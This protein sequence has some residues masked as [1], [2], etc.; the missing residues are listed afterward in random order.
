M[1]THLIA[2]TDDLAAF[3]ARQKSAGYVTVDT[4]FMRERTYWPQLCLAQVAG[5]EEA[6]AID[7]LAP[8]LNLGPLLELMAAPKVLK[9]FHAARQDLEIFHKLM[10]GNL[11]EPLFDTQVA[12]MVCGFGEAAAYET[13]VSKLAKKQVDKSSRFTDWSRRPLSDKQL[14]YAISDVTH[15][16]I[17]YDKLRAELEKSGRG[18]WLD[19]EMATL[20]DP[21]TYRMDPAESW[22]RLKPRSASA[23]MLAVLQEVAAWR[24]REA[25]RIDIP[26]Q[27]VLRDEAVMEIASHPP[28]NAADL[29]QIRG[30]SRGWADSRAGRELIDVV[31]RAIA[32]PDDKLPDR[33][34]A[35]PPMYVPPAVGD[36]LRVLLRLRCDESGVATKLVASSAELDLIAAGR[37][38]DTRALN[39]WR[40]GIFGDDARRLMRGELGLGLEGQKLTLF[41]RPKK[42][43]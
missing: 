27:R 22:K 7:T 42:G 5:P 36:M 34:K 14:A 28:R 11:P 2:T 32:I 19:E 23:R 8:D 26:R 1:K 4:E 39:G 41:E 16:R 12:G 31:A 6:A 3:C 30:V 40:A 37:G 33:I 9:V 20:T 29:S 15:L 13:L 38:E 35:P 18:E 10:A 21:A 43:A 17:V 25:Q 24:E